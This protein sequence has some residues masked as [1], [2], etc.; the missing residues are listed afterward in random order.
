MTWAAIAG[1]AA[2]VGGNLLSSWMGSQAT[3]AASDK[4]SKAQLWAMQ[5][6]MEMYYQGRRDTAPW[7]KAGQWGVNQ[8]RDL[9]GKGPGEYQKSPYYD[10]LMQQGTQGL[11]RGA[12]ARGKQFSG[13]ENKALM[14]YGQNLASTDYD[15]WLNRWYK[16]LTPYQSLAGLGQTSAENA[17][18]RGMQQGQQMGNYIGNWGEA[19][20]AGTL[21][22][23]NTWS[24]FGQWGGNQL[25]N[26]LMMLKG[27]GGRTLSDM[28]GS[29]NVWKE[30]N[31]GQGLYGGY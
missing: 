29:E 21:G 12:A 2:A 10:F 6:Q 5:Q 15:N 27:G 14:G 18:S 9:I 16:S 8:L 28:Y 31:Y 30:P 20:A 19:K 24:N 26:L 7:R 22:Q 13:A 4:M 17:A 23:A 1:G 25:A 11:E 3:G